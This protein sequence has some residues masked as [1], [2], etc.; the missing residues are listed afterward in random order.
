M[1]QLTC[2]HLCLNVCREYFFGVRSKDIE[3][4]YPS[5]LPPPP[6]Q[7]AATNE[8]EER[9]GEEEEAIAQDSEEEE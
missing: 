4:F 2:A 6:T 8:Q 9:K 5:E 7:A 3:D 1:Q